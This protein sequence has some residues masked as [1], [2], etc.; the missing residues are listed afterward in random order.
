VSIKKCS[1][2]E[3][4]KEMH[5]KGMC[6]NHYRESIRRANGS[7]AREKRPDI[8][9]AYKCTK[10]HYSMN[11]CMSHYA[12]FKSNGDV[13]EHVPIKKL[14]YGF[15]ECQVPRCK[16]PHHAVG[17]CRSHDATKRTYNL[18]T[19]KLIKMLSGSC[20]VCGEEDNLTIDHDHSCCNARFSCGSCV[21][22]C[23]CQHCNRSMGQAKDNPVILRKLADYIDKYK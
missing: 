11:Y 8:C 12:R 2:L 22:G 5:A 4:N 23:L 18:S 19:E 16:K 14:N 10:K 21:R 1:I 15:T 6:H 3:C 13:R 9:I 17:L 20:E 7:K